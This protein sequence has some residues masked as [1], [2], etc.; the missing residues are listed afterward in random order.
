MN[1][2]RRLGGGGEASEIRENA[3]WRQ[4]SVSR[5]AALTVVSQGP[6][7]G[8]DTKKSHLISTASPER[9]IQ[10]DPYHSCPF[11]GLGLLLRA[12]H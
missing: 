9:V 7:G 12:L 11:Q 8:K 2:S 1:K 4:S 3:G 6:T 10:E 5:T